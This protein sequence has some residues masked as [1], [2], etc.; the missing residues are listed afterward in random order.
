MTV[1]TL[2]VPSG[3]LADRYRAKSGRSVFAAHITHTG[4]D[5]R[6]IW[7]PGM[8]DCEDRRGPLPG[9]TAH[10]RLLADGWVLNNLSD[11]GETLMLDATWRAGTRPANIYGALWND[12]PVD[13]DTCS[14]L[15]GEPA[16]GGYAR[17]GWANNGTDFPTLA[18]DSGDYKL[19]GLQKGWTAAGGTIGPVTYFTFVSSSSGAGT[20]YAYMALSATRTMLTGDTLNVTP[21][22]KAA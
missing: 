14:T 5:G 19:T 10:A 18:L 3:R 8:G 22:L 7:V 1:T 21:A 9:D 11:G 4:P 6:L 13:T 15:T 17:V 16:T 12:T 20:L 2:P